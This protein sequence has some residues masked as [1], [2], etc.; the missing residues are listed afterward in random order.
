MQASVAS[1]TAKVDR[2]LQTVV[3]LA[4]VVELL[5]GQV[6][7]LELAAERDGLD[8]WLAEVVPTGAAD[9]ADGD[10]SRAVLRWRRRSDAPRQRGPRTRT[11]FRLRLKRGYSPL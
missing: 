11:R 2:M 9:V 1:L 3:E 7:R 10:A 5:A 4:A 8:L 6:Q